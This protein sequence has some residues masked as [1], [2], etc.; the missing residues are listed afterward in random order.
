LV[1]LTDAGPEALHPPFPQIS[2]E[3][4]YRGLPYFATAYQR[5]EAQDP[6]AYLAAHHKLLGIVKR[7]RK[8]DP[9]PALLDLTMPGKA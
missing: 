7:K 2:P 6:V 9:L 8:L 3:M 1:G 5:G 4:V